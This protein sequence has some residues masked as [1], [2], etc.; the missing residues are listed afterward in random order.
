MIRQPWRLDARRRRWF[1]W[2]LVGALLLVIPPLLDSGM[3]TWQ[4]WL[5][6]GMVLPLVW[7]RRHAYLV[8]WVVAAVCGLQLVFTEVPLPGQLAVPVAVFS[9]ARFE[10]ARR[11]AQ[12]LALGIL[13]AVLGTLDWMSPS[14]PGSLGPRDYV[15][16]MILV[17][18]IVLAAWALG[19]LA[20]TRQAYVDTLVERGERLEQEA[21]QRAELAASAERARIA[22]EMHDVVAHGLSVMVVQADGARY[23][24]ERDPQVALGAL[25]TISSTGREAL[26]EMRQLLGLL[27]SGEG[28][29]TAPQP[30]L[31]ELGALVAAAREGGLRVEATLP[32]GAD[33]P[34]GIAL[35]V[36]RVVQEALTN[37]R[38]HGGPDPAVE[39]VVAV[40]PTQVCVQ[41]HDDGRGAAASDDGDGHGL[42][43]MRERVEVHGGRLDAGPRPGGGF[44][45]SAR[46]PL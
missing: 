38:K 24:G 27:R 30:G 16:N 7:R 13:G 28:A 46:I 11:G 23:A 37:V 31:V 41:V 39:L 18:V 40:E 20:R 19:T 5:S 32:K 17:A 9:V 26:T 34:D 12:V 42:N 4:L 3:G 45:V 33:L 22:R 6:V 14:I 25:D 43:G 10:S 29:D 35:T 21:A 15:V 44:A 8:A 36:Y 2:A 1:D